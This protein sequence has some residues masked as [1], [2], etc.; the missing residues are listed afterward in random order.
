MINLSG[1]SYLICLK[2]SKWLVTFPLNASLPILPSLFSYNNPGSRPHYFSSW[3]FYGFLASLPDV[4]RSTQPPTRS[5][6]LKHLTVLSSLKVFN[7]S[8]NN[9][10]KLLNLEF[11]ALYK[12][13][14]NYL[15]N[16]SPTTF[17]KGSG[18]E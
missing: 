7:D 15:F 2:Y 17:W 11:R 8:T 10:I 14:P 6:F 12:E 9:I 13:V 3:L 18:K 5:L 4:I 16:P 1:K